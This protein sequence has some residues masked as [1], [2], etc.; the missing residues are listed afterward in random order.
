MAYSHTTGNDILHRLFCQMLSTLPLCIH[1][2][3]PPRLP[4]VLIQMC[5]DTSRFDTSLFSQL[6]N[7]VSCT[8]NKEYSPIMFSC[9]HA[10][11]TWRD[12][13]FCAISL[14]EFVSKQPVTPSPFPSP[15]YGKMQR[16]LDIT[17]AK[18]LAKFVCYY[19][20]ALYWGTFPYILLLL[21]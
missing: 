11:N 3:Y 19:E 15:A 20:V 18:G 21:G 1:I 13:F 4:V 14:L 6:I 7:I 5:F 8:W 10:S 2:Y 12:Q 17:S 16:N 9:S